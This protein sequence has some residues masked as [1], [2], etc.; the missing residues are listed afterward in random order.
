MSKTMVEMAKEINHDLIEDGRVT[1]TEG[2][3]SELPCYGDYFDKIFTVNTIYFWPQPRKD[4]LEVYRVLKKGGTLAIGV[5]SKDAMENFPA[6]KFGFNLYNI[7]DIEKLLIDAG[8]EIISSVQKD[9]SV[10]DA[11]CV[12]AKK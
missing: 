12:L 5:R 8:F 10:G 11:V 1:L 2:I 9:D 3:V 4:I 6:T 7:K